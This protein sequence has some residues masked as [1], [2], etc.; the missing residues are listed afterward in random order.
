MRIFGLSV[1]SVSY[2]V[3]GGDFPCLCFDHPSVKDRG[4][5]H[6]QGARHARCCLRRPG[7]PPSGRRDGTLHRERTG[8][9][10]G[11]FIDGTAW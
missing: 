9:R 2:P 11:M 10:N 1:T 8:S 7:G 6:L 4:G 3:G 5:V